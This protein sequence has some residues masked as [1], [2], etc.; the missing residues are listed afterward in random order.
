MGLVNMSER[1]KRDIPGHFHFV[2]EEH[3]GTSK[4]DRRAQPPIG[5]SLSR[6]CPI[7]SRPLLMKGNLNAEVYG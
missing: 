4:R 5:V 2:P 7:F 3:Q 1:D 6:V